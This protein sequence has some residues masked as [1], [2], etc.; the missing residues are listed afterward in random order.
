MKIA[1]DISQTGNSKAG[2][3][4]YAAALIDELLK[5]ASEHDFM[6]L[7][8]FG[9]FFHDPAMASSSARRYDGVSYGPCLKSRS[10]AEFFWRN[11]EQVACLFADIDVV[12]AN[13]FWCPP[14]WANGNEARPSLIY[15]LYDLSFAEHPEWTTEANRLGCFNGMFN[16]SLHADWFVAIS[17]PLGSASC[18]TFP[19]WIL[20]G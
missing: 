1:F 20:P 15:T 2:C 16:A 12:H 10:K 7:T 8:S 9:D 19:T 18:T 5:S 6:L 4:F 17:K 11:P 14:T 13:N 3:G